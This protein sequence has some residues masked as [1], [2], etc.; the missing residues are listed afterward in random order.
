MTVVVGVSPVSGSPQALRWAAEEARLRNVPV[1]AVLAWRMPSPSAAPAGRPPGGATMPADG[2]YRAAAELELREH[3]R[4]ALG[5]DAE[6]EYVVARGN[7]VNALLSNSDGADLI[8]V[9]DPGAGRMAN[10]RAGM[11]APRLLARAK[12]PV[13]V[14]PTAATA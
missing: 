6:V 9:G 12:C 5:N 13:V 3:V 8:V 14:V 7:P 10:M 2:N 4:T 1:R 11:A